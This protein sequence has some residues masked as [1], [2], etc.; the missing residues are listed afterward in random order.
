MNGE[1]VRNW[2]H[3]YLAKNKNKSMAFEVE[4]TNSAGDLGAAASVSFQHRNVFKGSETFMMKCVALMR[5]LRDWG[6]LH[7]IM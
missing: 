6:W 5:P 4:G 3:T 1:M 7:R 2:T